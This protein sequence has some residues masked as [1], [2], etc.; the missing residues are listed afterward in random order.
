MQNK[1]FISQSSKWRP[2]A[3]N[4]SNVYCFI[5]CSVSHT[6]KNCKQH[7]LNIEYTSVSFQIW[8]CHSRATSCLH[9][10][11]MKVFFY[12]LRRIHITKATLNYLNG[13][14]DVEPGS[15][16]ER[17]TSISRSTTLKPSSLWAAVRSGMRPFF[18]PHQQ[19]V[20]VQFYKFRWNKTF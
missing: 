4:N 13:D 6:I 2:L 14:Y 9:L 17:K 10:C 20:S 18:S 1:G 8:R 7:I 19:M 12:H 11:L 3:D 5:M 15:G 16:G